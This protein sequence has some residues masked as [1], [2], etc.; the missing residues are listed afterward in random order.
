MDL[1]AAA[2]SVPVLSLAALFSVLLPVIMSPAVA[3]P[4]VAALDK[5]EPK[6]ITVEEIIKRFSIKEKA[7]KEARD[8]Y[9][10]RQDV[11]VMTLEGDTPDGFYQQGFDVPFAEKGRKTKNA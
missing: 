6:G 4:Q 8:Q 1:H 5:S 10:F 7:F 3:H 2:N 9:T 11:K